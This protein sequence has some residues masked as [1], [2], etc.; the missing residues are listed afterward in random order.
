MEARRLLDAT[1]TANV[2]AYPVPVGP[3]LRPAAL[4][5]REEPP[6]GPTPYTGHLGMYGDTP[7]GEALRSLTRR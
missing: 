5:P 3:V 6:Q 1:T 2:G 4:A 7:M